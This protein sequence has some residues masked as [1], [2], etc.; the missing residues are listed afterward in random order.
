MQVD[1]TLMLLGNIISN[2]SLD[3][4]FKNISIE[5]VEPK[6]FSRDFFSFQDIISSCIVPEDVWD[7]RLFKRPP[8]T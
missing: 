3:M 7:L 5:Q 4:V 6:M 2:V 1:A 8:S